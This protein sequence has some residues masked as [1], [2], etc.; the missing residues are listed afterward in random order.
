[1][2]LIIAS[3]KKWFKIDKKLYKQHEVMEITKSSELT[4]ANIDNY[5][6]NFIF[7]PHWS[8]AVPESI[9]LHNRCILFHTAPLPYGRGGSPI[10]N[11]ILNGYTKAPVCALEMEAELDAGN[12]LGKFDID[13]NGKLSDIFTR[14]NMAI[15]ILIKEIITSYPKPSPQKGEVVKFKR[16]KEADNEIPKELSINQIFDRIRMLDDDEYPNAF[17]IK[18]NY[19]IEFFNAEKSG[20]T[21][22]CMAKISQLNKDNAN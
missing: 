12:I 17:M 18:D 15:N 3:S 19:K 2:K 21:L 13:L 14:M 4:K 20:E 11:L 5:C 7:F 10:Q 1:M 6:P 9:Y 16:L 8:W 22:N